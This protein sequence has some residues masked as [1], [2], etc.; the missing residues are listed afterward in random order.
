MLLTKLKMALAL[1]LVAALGLGLLI[2]SSLAQSQP[3]VEGDKVEKTSPA[4]V[5]QDASLS[6]E[7]K[8]RATLAGHTDMVW[9]VVYSPDGKTLATG[10]HD[11]TIKLWDVSTGK[12]QTTLK[13]HGTGVRSVAFSPDGKT[14]ASGIVGSPGATDRIKLWDVAT[15]TERATLMGR[16]GCDGLGTVAFSPDGKTLA[17]TEYNPIK[18]WDVTTN[19]ERAAL[20]GHTGVV[21]CVAF[22]PDGKTL[23]SGSLDKTVKLWDLSTGKERATL[24]GHTKKVMSVA[25]S[26]DGKTLASASEDKIIK[27]WEVATGKER[28]FLQ[29]H[30]D[31]VT[32][33][34]F[35]PDGITLASASDDKTIKL[36][37]VASGK[38]RAFLQGHSDAVRS[39]TF[40]PDGKT[41]ASASDDQTV[42]LWDMPAPKQKESARGLT[43]AELDDLW[44]ALAAEDAVKADQAIGTLVGATEQAVALMKERLRPVSEPNAQQI[45]TWIDDLDSDQFHVREKA[46]AELEKLGERTETVLRNKLTEKASPEL[47]RRIEQLLAKIGQLTPDTM[48][49]LRAVEVLEHIGS[50]EARKVLE[51]L[52]AGAEST[53]LNSEAKASLGR[54]KKRVAADE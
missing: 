46:G 36:W 8:V 16:G 20:E 5:D 10:S 48:R 35:S 1:L 4:R 19:K 43:P 28:A 32:S 12:E 45:A 9:S 27:L 31:A 23:A 37:D 6:K 15:G 40:S 51:A 21:S 54:L 38:D 29:G 7:S 47:R 25:Y 26:P 39:V 34:A 42:K 11:L 3:G 24:Q 30:S 22:S 41:L 14:L 50:S 44:S 18:L 49:A 53:R 33:V 13:G 52:A 2:H 17:T